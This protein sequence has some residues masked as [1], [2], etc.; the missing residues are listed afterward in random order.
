MAHTR[1]EGNITGSTEYLLVEQ[2]AATEQSVTK[3]DYREKV[4]GER[5]RDTAQRRR[6]I[7]ASVQQRRFLV[8]KAP[9]PAGFSLARAAQVFYLQAVCLPA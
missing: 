2:H 4:A 5:K 7:G 6:L 1:L 8:G 9:L 3:G